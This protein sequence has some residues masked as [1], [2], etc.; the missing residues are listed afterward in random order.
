MEPRKRSKLIVA[1]LAAITSVLAS[2]CGFP[3]PADV[4]DDASSCC[5]TPAECAQLGA[6]RPQPC[7]LG[8][9]VHNACTTA[10][11]ACDGDED[12]GGATPACADQVCSVCRV[13]TSCPAATPVCDDT[14]HDCRACAKDSECDSG[15]C[16]LAAGT[17]VDRGAILYASPGGTM[18]DP[19]TLTS[20]CSL[21][22]AAEVVDADH[23]YIV[24]LPGRHTSGALFDGK[25]ATI[26]G[27]GATIDIVVEN[28]SIGLQNQASIRMRD[29]TLED[30]IPGATGDTEPAI[31]CFLSPGTQFLTIDNMI[32]NT[33]NIPPFR[34]NV[35]T[36]RHS[37]VSRG[38]ISDAL[39]ADGCL[40]SG[41]GPTFRES[42]IITNSIFISQGTRTLDF[43]PD[44]LGSTTSEITN[45]TFVGGH[46]DCQGST[47]DH[48]RFDSNIFYNLDTIVPS[49]SCEYDYNL[50]TPGPN[51]QGLANMIGDPLFVDVAHNDFHLKQGSPAIDAADPNLTS[52]GHDFDGIARPLGTR[53]DIGAF[54]HVP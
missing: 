22:K 40:F 52:N 27:N 33:Q 32:S 5:V 48:V 14:S 28:Q 19:C 17:C 11:G 49:A 35:L 7:P 24:L 34:A 46:L 23:E 50:L 29:F 18:A 10:A 21:A 51:L 8:A 37:T 12:C 9:C 47:I 38:F 3:R 13:S 45:N 41:G 15:A 42:S 31:V 16:D 54:E 53:S 36:I 25:K 26:V 30:H 43:S 39:F 2:A 20:P 44:N 1:A 4:G 6:S